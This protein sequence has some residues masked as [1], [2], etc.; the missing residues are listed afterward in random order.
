M[1]QGYQML[2]HKPVMTP[3]LSPPSLDQVRHLRIT[4]LGG[5]P[6]VMPPILRS[7]K[8]V[9]GPISIIHFDAHLDSLNLTRGYSGVVSEQSIFTH[10]TFF[11][12]AALEG[13]VANSSVSWC[14][15]TATL[16]M[17]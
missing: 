6:S 8:Y 4:S 5:D 14:R 16:T 17:N 15:S 11:W 12:R 7:L 1:E 3:A 2:S 9:S 10:G 13:C